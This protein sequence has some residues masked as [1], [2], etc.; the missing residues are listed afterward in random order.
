MKKLLAC[1]FFVLSMAALYSQGMIQ[2]KGVVYDADSGGVLDS[3][4][5][6]V[7]GTTR[8]MQNKPDGS[9]SIFIKQTDTLVF[10]LYGYR[11]KYLCFKDSAKDKDYSIKV[12]LSHFMEELREVTIREVRTQREVRKDLYYLNI[13]RELSDQRANA[14][15]SP[16]TALYEAYNK[17]A[18]SK[19]ILT[20]YEF[21]LA[22][23]KLIKELLTIYNKQGI[24]EIPESKYK[25]FLDYLNLDWDFLAN[26]S[27]YDLAEYVKR[28][29][30]E[31]SGK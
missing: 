19:Q 9:F 17:K 31:W 16:I 23:N 6:L 26:A 12:K 8:I 18:R 15:Q 13:G 20:A 4:T 10:G 30:I 22:K 1:I 3:V 27:D 28:K 2:V 5:V 14:I 21:E 11:V 24:I 29:A 7:K 25:D